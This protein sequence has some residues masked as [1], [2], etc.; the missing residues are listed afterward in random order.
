[1]LKRVVTV[2][3]I[4]AIRFYQRFLSP[5]KPMPTCRF[6]PTCSSYA[7][8]AIQRRGVARGTLMAL[9]RILRCNPFFPGGFD[10]VEPRSRD[11]A[12]DWAHDRPQASNEEHGCAS[13]A[14]PEP[15][16]HPNRGAPAG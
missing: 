5:L 12:R 16:G 2:V 6:L 1:M 4:A 3:F 7:L 15:A 10:P 8:E 14:Q 13:C 11:W 9:W